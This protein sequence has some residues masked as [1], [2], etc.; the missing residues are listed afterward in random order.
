MLGTPEEVGEEHTCIPCSSSLMA[1]LKNS[2]ISAK[3]GFHLPTSLKT[4]EEPRRGVK[5]EEEQVR[6]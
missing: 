2:I 6:R 4:E 5:K 3:A 1:L